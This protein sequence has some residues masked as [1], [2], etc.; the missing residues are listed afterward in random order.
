M[1]AA[2]KRWRRRISSVQTASLT[3]AA[4]LFCCAPYAAFAP[5]SA[6]PITERRETTGAAPKTSPAAAGAGGSRAPFVAMASQ[7]APRP[8]TNPTAIKTGGRAY[9]FRG[10]LGLIFSRGMDRLAKRI[11]QTGVAASVSEFTNCRSIAEQ[12]VRDHRQDPTPIIIIGHSMGGRCAL[13]FAQVLQAENIQAS[14]VVTIDPPQISPNVPQNV[15]RYINIFLSDS[16]FGAD[17]AP[18]KGYQGHFASF[19]LSKHK[20]MMHINIDKKE[21]IHDQLI[22]KIRQLAATATA[23]SERVPI[24]YVVPANAAIELW[25][26]GMPIFARSGDTVAQ[27]AAQHGVPLWSVTQINRVSDGTLLTAGQRIVV[28]RHLAPLPEDPGRPPAKP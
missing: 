9:L 3:I 24:R 11:G 27:L 12:A 14:L 25:D 18:E 1:P 21:S 6:G 19:D 20:G 22:T 23:E 17:V 8:A 5:A 16:V 15:A 13:R 7:A 2:D 26:S 28:P 4:I 10:A